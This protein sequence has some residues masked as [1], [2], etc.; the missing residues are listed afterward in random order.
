VLFSFSCPAQ[1]TPV[2]ND[3]FWDAQFGVPGVGAY[4][5][6]L[7]V[8]LGGGKLY[9]GGGFT[10]AG[11]NPALNIACWDGTNWNNMG[12][13]ITGGD[14][15]GV[16]ALATK[17]NEVFAGGWFFQAGTTSVSHIARWDGTN[18]SS[19]NGGANDIVFAVAADGNDVYIAGS[20]QSVGGVGATNIARWDG[21]NKLV[22]IRRGHRRGD[23]LPRGTKRARLRRRKLQ[24]GWR[25][26]RH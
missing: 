23:L 7:A 18:W 2:P 12:G 16:Y 6:V 26:Q 4:E 21:T 25:R 15:P 3:R 9:V 1:I 5:S 19:L 11:G 13:G 22:A 24:K 8:A 10:S 17:G 14:F 20:F